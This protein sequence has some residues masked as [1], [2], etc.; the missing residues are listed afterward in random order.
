MKN[1]V[2]RLIQ[3]SSVILML[4]IAFGCDND[5]PGGEKPKETISLERAHAMYKA[6]Q[7]RARA[8]AE[9][10]GGEE[11]AMYGWHSLDFYEKYIAYLKH[12]SS[13]VGIK[14]SGLR[15]YYVAYPENDDSNNQSDY[16]TYI[17]V[18]TYYDKNSGKHIAFDPLHIGDDGVPL[19]IHDIIVNGKGRSMDKTSSEATTMARNAVEE[20]ESS[21]GNMAEMCEPNCN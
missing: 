9:L 10:K 15:M 18:P 1:K 17:Y 8:L 19:P 12:A 21:I 5:K 20:T 14:V 7:E 6:Y 11:D 13:K 2:N 16:Q 3:V 4:L